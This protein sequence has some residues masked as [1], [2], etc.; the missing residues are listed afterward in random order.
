[1]DKVRINWIDIA[2]GIGIILVIYGHVLSADSVRHLMYSFHMP[3]FFFL[4]GIVF[5][6]KSYE[7]FFSFFKKSFKNIMLPYFIFAAA[8]YAVA[9]LI[10]GIDKLT[11]QAFSKQVFGILYGSGSDGYLAFNVALWFLPCL[12][13]TRILF[14]I[15]TKLT[16]KT[17]YIILVL[18]GFSIAG[19]LFSRKFPDLDLPYG[20]EIALSAVVFFGAGYLWNMYSEKLTTIF[21]KYMLVFLPALLAVCIF[22]AQLNFTIYDF[23]IDMRLNRLNNYAFFYL[24]ALSGIFGTLAVSILIGK[25]SILEYLGKHSLILFV[26]HAIVF[27][28]ITRFLLLFMERSALYQYKNVYF[29]PVYTVVAIAVI[30]G[31]SWLFNRLKLQF[32]KKN[33][34]S[35][36]KNF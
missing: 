27:T 11:W 6:H 15:I 14:W 34:E 10:N 33:V 20:L 36:E 28:Y 19:F 4:S 8:T 24:A 16:D 5:H 9:I 3:L 13:A 2:R 23:Q 18:T 29:A 30:L 21:K 12:F 31:M 25:N 17:A 7:T 1:M 32:M 35:L 26:W 22:F